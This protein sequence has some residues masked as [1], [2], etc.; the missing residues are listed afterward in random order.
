MR[1][2][3]LV[4]TFLFFIGVSP[5]F[6]LTLFEEAFDGSD[7]PTTLTYMS[8]RN[9][10]SWYIDSSNRLYGDRFQMGR[11]RSTFAAL[12]TSGFTLNDDGIRYSA[13]MGRPTVSVNPETNTIHGVSD[14]GLI[15]GGYRVLFHP[16]YAGWGGLERGRFRIEEWQMEGR[17]L[18]LI[19]GTDMGFIP[20]LDYLHHIE[21]FVTMDG[22]DL[23]IDISISGLGTDSLMHT[24]NYTYYGSPS[25]LG[26]GRVG[27]SIHG[28][29]KDDAFFDNLMVEGTGAI[30]HIRG[31]DDR[32]S[33]DKSNDRK[34]HDSDLDPYIKMQDDY[35]KDNGFGN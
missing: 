20:A 28:G 34:N 17:P 1:K 22:N 30:I 3:I 10:N 8:D 4:I 14:A 6:A 2:L 19:V 13:D 11:G 31:K 29:N 12:S 23:K 32:S 35:L 5:A 33:D 16:G 9:L 25:V 7:L 21:V 27:V 18:R 24:F 15:F 26:V